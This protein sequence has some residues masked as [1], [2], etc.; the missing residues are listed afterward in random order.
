MQ[1]NVNTIA[2]NLYRCIH[3]KPAYVLN[4]IQ[5]SWILKSEP[6]GLL[7]KFFCE[8]NNLPVVFHC[9]CAVG[10]MVDRL[11]LASITPQFNK[12]LR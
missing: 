7:Q 2:L 1:L 11:E 3:Y 10:S 6:S 9:F 8:P 5:V 4:A 12:I